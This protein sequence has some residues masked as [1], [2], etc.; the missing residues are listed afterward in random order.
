MFEEVKAKEV[1]PSKLLISDLSESSIIQSKPSNTNS[2]L[3]LISESS[4]RNERS[5]QNLEFS[6]SLNIE[7]SAVSN[8]IRVESSEEPDWESLEREEQQV[9]REPSKLSMSSLDQSD[10]RQDPSSSSFSIY[11]SEKPAQTKELHVESLLEELIDQESFASKDS[12]SKPL[13]SEFSVNTTEGG[14]LDLDKVE[15]KL[16]IEFGSDEAAF[17]D[18][19]TQVFQFVEG[20]NSRRN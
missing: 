11:Q 12:R 1:D 17:D 10:S 7:D 18:K 9:R 6:S 5:E 3:L 14:N 8:V 15:R 2:G 19:D 20:K 13:H 16:G 4:F